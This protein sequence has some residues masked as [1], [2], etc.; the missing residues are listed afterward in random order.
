MALGSRRRAPG[1]DST[2]QICSGAVAKVVKERAAYLA[3]LVFARRAVPQDDERDRIIPVEAICVCW[4]GIGWH[5]EA[6]CR[7][8]AH[9]TRDASRAESSLY[10]LDVMVTTGVDE[11]CARYLTELV[12]WDA[13]GWHSAN[14]RWCGDL[15]L[16]YDT[17]AAGER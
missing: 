9:A 3:S 11:R 17:Q 16:D 6:R 13:T 4:G 1:R 2:L 12:T 15:K 14:A 10:G 7:K 5:G 8:G